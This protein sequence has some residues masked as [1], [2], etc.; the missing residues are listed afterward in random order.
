MAATNKITTKRRFCG[1]FQ[2]GKKLIKFD[3]FPHD[4]FKAIKMFCIFVQHKAYGC[5]S[6][7]KLNSRGEATQAENKKILII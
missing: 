6:R 5:V 7:N 2:P 1:L 3:I 4:L